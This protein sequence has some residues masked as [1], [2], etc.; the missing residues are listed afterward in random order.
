MAEIDL[1][2]V[3][4]DLGANRRGVDMGPSAL[5][6]AG[7]AAALTR[8]GHRVRETGDV[9][10]A[11]PEQGR[12]GDPS[13]RYAR[14]IARTCRRLADRVAR[15]VRE[16]RVPLV[17]GGDHSI[18]IGTAVGLAEGGCRFG[19]LWV[20]AHADINTPQTSPSGN[21]H[22]MAL[23]AMLG[24][25]PAGMMEP[26]L[27]CRARPP[28]SADRVAIVAVRDVDPGERL[29]LRETGIAVYTMAEID[30]RGAAAVIDA[31]LEH[32]L[33]RCDGLYVSFDLDALDPAVAPG[34]GTPKEGGLTYREGHL[35][36][37]TVAQTGALRA[38]EVVEINPILDVANR[39]AQIACELIG[40]AFGASVL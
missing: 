30:R 3:P 39:T 24:L 1:I 14:E 9:A 26:A 21:V 40:S 35:I 31:A 18:A 13:A 36:L 10:V 27:S 37:E 2:G 32:L 23:A 6:Y 12:V 33:A 34:V 28:A 7:V 19:L 20:D 15:S 17:V 4:M 5:R 29:T 25:E 16:R 22:G 11:L 38:F 8:M